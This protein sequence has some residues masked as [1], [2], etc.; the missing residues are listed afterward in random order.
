MGRRGQFS[1]FRRFQALSPSAMRV[2]SACAAA[3]AAHGQK[4]IPNPDCSRR[5]RTQAE[6]DWAARSAI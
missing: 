1:P 4:A 5:T 2:L 6:R 3:R